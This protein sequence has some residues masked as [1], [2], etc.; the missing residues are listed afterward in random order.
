M[1]SSSSRGKVG[2]RGAR[3]SQPE[4][5]HSSVAPA[6]LK[7]TL[8]AP[9]PRSAPPSSQAPALLPASRK[10]KPE[11]KSNNQLLHA[12]LQT[13]PAEDDGSET[14][15]AIRDALVEQ[16]RAL[17]VDRTRANTK[18]VLKRFAKVQGRALDAFERLAKRHKM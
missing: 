6:D 7:E 15:Q 11:K 16:K 13:S 4:T 5:T 3:T 8:V 14:R 2:N 12:L 17:A 9:K 10:A 18:A 1:P